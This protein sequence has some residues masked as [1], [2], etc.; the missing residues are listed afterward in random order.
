MIPADARPVMT[1]LVC[2]Y[3]QEAYGGAFATVNDKA[4]RKRCDFF[5]MI[6]YRTRTGLVGGG[7]WTAH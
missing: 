3:R 4:H 1:C 6:R 7:R 2:G 5:M